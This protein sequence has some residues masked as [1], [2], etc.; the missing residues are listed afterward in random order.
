MPQIE[1][2]C[3][4]CEKAFQFWPSQKQ[5]FCSRSCRAK[6]ALMG[7]RRHGESVPC[8]VCGSVVYRTPAQ[9]IQGEVKY[10]SPACSGIGRTKDAVP[11][12][13][14]HCGKAFT[15]RPSQEFVKYCSREC[16]TLGTVKRPLER[17]HNGKR[18]KKDR[19]GYVMVWEPEHPNQ[20][21]RGWQYEHRLVAERVLGRHLESAEHV[22]HINGVKDDNRPE[23]LAVMGHL[24][25][26][27]LSGQEHRK[28]METMKNELEEY[29]RRYGPLG[30]T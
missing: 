9:M 12:E 1:G 11:K 16:W 4:T 7:R 6:S 27:A 13:C 30:G 15:V 8:A 20:T 19:A 2:R 18:A 24:E 21:Q 17:L 22:H 14:A 28:E 3:E 29:R 26:L 25:H 23:N 10:C 5:R